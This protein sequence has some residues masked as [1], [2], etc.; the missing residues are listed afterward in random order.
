[1]SFVLC[2]PRAA[3]ISALKADNESAAREAAAQQ[4]SLMAQ[5]NAK[6][7]TA[8]GARAQLAALQET[9]SGLQAELR[10]GKANAQEDQ[11]AIT[12]LNR[13]VQKV[14]TNKPSYSSIHKYRR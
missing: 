10:A 4:S 5:V 8:E 12:Q 9:I 7:G 1:V 3:Q 6:S 2:T 11:Q 14:S 13:Q